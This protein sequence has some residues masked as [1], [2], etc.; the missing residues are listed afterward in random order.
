MKKKILL[1]NYLIKKCVEKEQKLLGLN[2]FRS[3]LLSI[4]L[5]HAN[6]AR[7]YAHGVS[8]EDIYFAHIYLPEELLLAVCLNAE[9]H[10]D[11][12]FHLFDFHKGRGIQG[13]FHR[14]IY[15]KDDELDSYLETIFPDV[16]TEYEVEYNLYKTVINL[17]QKELITKARR[18][19][20][21]CHIPTEELELPEKCEE[22]EIIDRAFE[23]LEKD[24]LF[25]CLF[26]RGY[27]HN[28]TGR[29][30]AL[31]YCFNKENIDI[32]KDIF[33]E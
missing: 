11:K 1:L 7:R 21:L 33:G 15:I 19:D 17:P 16:K 4:V 29:S 28:P 6:I 3:G 9:R 30:L 10:G 23:R 12:L 18:I 8:T 5:S 24:E 14:E 31:Y 20:N 32:I 13:K 22:T 25:N 26:G 2:D 27:K